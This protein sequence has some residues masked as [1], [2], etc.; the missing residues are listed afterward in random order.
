M[1]YSL[2]V[3]ALLCGFGYYHINRADGRE[4]CQRNL[5]V[6][7][8]AAKLTGYG[9]GDRFPPSLHIIFPTAPDPQ[10]YVCPVSGHDAGDTNHA[11]MW[12]DYVYV[13]GLTE[14]DPP[15]CVLAFCPPQNHKDEGA[16]VLFVD[17]SVR[18]Y[19]VK[20]FEKLTNNPSAFFGTTNSVL[21]NEIRSRTKI[22]YPNH[23]T[24][25]SK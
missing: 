17:G 5:R 19:S 18:W 9:E 14:S 25:Q 20:E 12:T 24:G 6:I 13:S 2:T 8:K 7:W 16:N 22:M 10:L 11:N 23:G 3:L 4:S 1:A 21:H 15:S